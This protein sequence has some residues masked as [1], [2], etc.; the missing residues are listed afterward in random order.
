MKVVLTNPPRRKGQ[1]YRAFYPSL[2][3]LYLASYAETY[4]QIRNLEINYIEGSAY[5]LDEF[6]KIISKINPDV[7]GFTF[8]T[9]TSPYAYEAINY[10]KRIF[11][12]IL[13]V[14][15]GPHATAMPFDVLKNSKTD[16]CVIGEGEVTF[17]ELL[18]AYAKH[19]KFHDIN[20]IAFRKNDE[21]IITPSRSLISNL[22]SIP[23]PAW[24]KVDLK[25]YSG[26]LLK[27]SWPD[28]CIMSTRGC[29]FNCVFC[30]NPVWKYNMPW[31]RMR[32]PENVVKEVE[33]LGSYG[34]KEIF[35]Y[36]DEFNADIKWAIK[37]AEAISKSKND[38]SFKLQLRADRITEK[39]VQAISKMNCWLAHVGIESGC[40]ATLN[41]IN[42]QISLQQVVKGLQLLKKYGIKTQ[43]FFMILNVWEENG[44]LRFESPEMC[45]PTL[46]FV[47]KLISEELIDNLSWSITTPLPGSRLYDIC[48]RH[49]LIDDHM[50]F[51]CFD[52]ERLVMNL[53]GV[54][55]NDVA[56]I[57][58][59][60]MFLQ[61][62]CSILH[63]NVN[64]RNGLILLDKIKTMLKYGFESLFFK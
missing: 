29:P 3:L 43:G 4:T 28:A 25:K 2:G 19:R 8:T 22:D 14:C 50:D 12:D 64:L 45:R 49:N 56:K 58:F 57:K 54:R 51:S 16:I 11:P 61:V 62:Y 20:G 34:V 18:E 37:V 13:V 10:I 15:G 35:D 32:S 6:V 31:F 47:R 55:A 42:K 27:K 60:G 7:V 9:P 33:F 1:R 17:L 46:K 41:G 36:A 40:Q 44:Q 59:Q 5:D 26:Y 52:T 24:S 38:I 63:G 30:S 53:P 23:F 39:L 21:I 48:L